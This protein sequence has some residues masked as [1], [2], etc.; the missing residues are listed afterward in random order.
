MLTLDHDRIQQIIDQLDLA[1]TNH[2]N[3]FQNINRTLVCHT[4]CNAKYF[5]QDAFRKCNFGHWYYNPDNKALWQHDGFVA[6]EHEHINMHSLAT[7]LLLDSNDNMATDIDRYDLFSRSVERLHLQIHSLQREL[8]DSLLNLD[9]LTGA[10]TRSGMLIELRRQHQL[11]KRKTLAC[12]IAMLDLDEFKLINDN[13]GHQ[14]GDL[15]LKTIVRYILDKTR[16]YDMVYRYG[17]D[18]FLIC[19][20]GTDLITANSMVERL[21][22]GIE[23]LA[24]TGSGM[25]KQHI[26][27]SFGIT[28]LSA[29]NFVEESI[30]C[31]DQAL[32][33]AKESGR[34]RTAMWETLNPPLA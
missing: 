8:Q 15:A 1:I 23:R 29:D 27:A 2:E 28:A 12:S 17:G 3:W 26:T 6:I 18:E 14:A 11:V 25:F 34:N 19:L 10:R 20:P 31:A 22:S 4:P 21:R 33:H 16:P 9:S 24:I 13:Y 30:R 7:A 5:S 32:Y